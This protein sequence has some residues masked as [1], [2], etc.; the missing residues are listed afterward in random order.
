MYIQYNSQ[1]TIHEGLHKRYRPTHNR[2]RKLYKAPHN[3]AYHAQQML[4][5]HHSQM[6]LITVHRLAKMSHT[7]VRRW[8]VVDPI[9]DEL[10]Q[11]TTG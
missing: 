8:P 1:N 10:H 9:S 4:T 6:T 11:V 5:P 3:S 2:T 7:A